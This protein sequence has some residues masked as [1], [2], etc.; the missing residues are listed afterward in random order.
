MD[1]TLDEEQTL[2]AQSLR[3]LL[4]DLCTGADL[5][6]AAEAP[7][8]AAFAAACATRAQRIAE[9]GLAGALVAEAQGGLGLAPV[10]FVALAEEAGRAALPEPLVDS[11]G[12]A[13]PLLARLAEA[14]GGGA[15]ADALARALAGE[16][17]V[18]CVPPG[19]SHVAALAAADFVLA[20]ADDAELALHARESLGIA[21]C[22]SV[23]PLR[24]PASIV[25]IS[26][27]P[28]ATLRGPVAVEAW[29]A[30]RARG[31]VFG[32]AQH[33]G[34]ASRMVEI[35][36]AYAGE[37]K[38]FGRPIGSN[39]AVKHHLADVQVKIEFARPVVYAAAAA[40]GP[41]APVGSAAE[42]RA[43]HAALAAG[44]AADL[45]ART[46]IQ[47]HGAMGYSWELDLQFYAKR[48]WALAGCHG[49]R[50]AHARR[51]HDALCDGTIALGPD[52]LFEDRG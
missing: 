13:L 25:A 22:A 52:V 5:R 46:A 16:A 24:R 45:A 3:E 4:A 50:A 42:L 21:A 20:G 29:R 11:A 32:A 1:F 6:R 41:E 8:A 12:V 26:G 9:L 23:D 27:A 17:V 38:Q 7:D 33:L 19:T 49:G 47:V 40:L 30:T 35:A 14:A 51:V 31:A 36:V 44:D 37:R 15:A 28:L 34:L 39:Q 43:S 10:D 18:L 48:A 2:A